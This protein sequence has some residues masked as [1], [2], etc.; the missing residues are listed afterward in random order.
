M[1]PS[2]I[3]KD[4]IQKIVLSALGFVALLYVYFSFFLGPLNKGRA[5]AEAGIA[6][7]QGKLSSSKSEMAKAK[8]LS[9]QAAEATARFAALKA[10]SP[11]GA[12]I[13]WFP[14]RLKLFF[15]NQSVDKAT[16]RLDGSAPFKEPEMAEWE[17]YSWAMD[18]P[19]TDFATLGH[20]LAEL[21]NS[22]PLLAVLRID[23]KAVGSDPEF[24]QVTLNA[25]STLRK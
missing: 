23:I 4:Q 6:D 7:L 1:T 25:T 24:Q 19:Q 16:I 5:T 18:F 21:E 12:P 17:K 9:R 20:A 15:A 11:E 13:A 2:K 8:N 10:L 14:P 3:S 22:E